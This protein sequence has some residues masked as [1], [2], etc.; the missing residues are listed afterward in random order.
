[1]NVS[2]FSITLGFGANVS[3]SRGQVT[4]GQHAIATAGVEPPAAVSL[5][6]SYLGTPTSMQVSPVGNLSSVQI[7]G[8]S[9]DYEGIA[10]LG[11]YLDFSG[12][13]GGN[14]TLAGQG[15]SAHVHA[16]WNTTGTV[17]VPLIVTT[18]A[19]PGSVIDWSLTNLSYGLSIGIHAIG[20]VLDV[21][22]VSAQVVRFGSLGEVL[23]DPS[24]FE[25]PYS[26]VAPSPSTPSGIVQ[27]LDSIPG[28]AA[29]IVLGVA[30]GIVVGVVLRVRRRGRLP[31]TSP[32]SP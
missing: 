21:G 15:T 30:A 5:N 20:Y 8:L 28:V 12:V 13:I 22:V 27:F 29:L 26:V 7:P 14:L 2:N 9:Y 32:P 24:T 1:V 10:E 3:M 25:E 6:I 16:T 31:G 4:P 18:Y 23:G 19:S 11:L 17:S